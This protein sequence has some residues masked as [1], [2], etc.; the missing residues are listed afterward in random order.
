MLCPITGNFIAT[1]ITIL[2]V[3]AVGFAAI[4]LLKNIPYLKKVVN[5]FI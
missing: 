5:K 4:C 1:I 3:M 2:A